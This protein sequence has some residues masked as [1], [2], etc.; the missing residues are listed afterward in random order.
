[1]RFSKLKKKKIQLELEYVLV[2]I[3][4]CSILV[5]KTFIVSTLC[6]VLRAVSRHLLLDLM[7][8]I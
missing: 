4:F 8:L 2:D 3:T 1:M 5:S 7:E 6:K